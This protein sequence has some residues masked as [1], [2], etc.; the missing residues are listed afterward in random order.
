[1]DS[2]PSVAEESKSSHEKEAKARL[3]FGYAIAEI[4]I[5]AALVHFGSHFHDDLTFLSKS[6]TIRASICNS[7]GNK[8]IVIDSNYC[9]LRKNQKAM[10]D[11]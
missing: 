11:S 8:D 4:E 10:N 3:L 2:I 1:M 6:I 5:T 9:F 7:T